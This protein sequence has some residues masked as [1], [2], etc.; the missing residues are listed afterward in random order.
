[1]TMSQYKCT[2]HAVFS[3]AH[4]YVHFEHVL[5]KNK[6]LLCQNYKIRIW[7]NLVSFN[8]VMYTFLLGHSRVAN[9][10]AVFL[11]MPVYIYSKGRMCRIAQPSHAKSQ[12]GHLAMAAT[13][14]GCI[15]LF[16]FNTRHH[17]VSA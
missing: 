1:M 9:R 3:Y 8:I 10:K 15:L 2:V 16:C 11:C 12:M 6:D 17:Y 5:H 13:V 14:H 7:Q 4:L